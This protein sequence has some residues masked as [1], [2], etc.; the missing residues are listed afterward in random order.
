MF[1]AKYT[2]LKFSIISLILFIPYIFL[3]IMA[4]ALEKSGRDDIYIFYLIIF[5]LVL[6]WINI[7]ANRIRDF[8]NNPWYA[9]WALIPPV[10]LGMAFYYGILKHK[11]KK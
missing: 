8:G 9:L 7:L 2:R 5:A 10:N 11:S 3:N 1:G 6:I 4:E